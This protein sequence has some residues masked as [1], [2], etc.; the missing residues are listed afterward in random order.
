MKHQYPTAPE[1]KFL[2][3]IEE[4]E[5]YVATIVAMP[6]NE[7]ELYEDMRKHKKYLQ[8]SIDDTEKLQKYFGIYRL[9]ES[10][11]INF[12]KLRPIILEV[13]ASGDRF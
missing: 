6:N 4:F 10:A 11:I 12:K 13:D 9:S 5:R 2:S 8:E 7:N 3:F 1:P